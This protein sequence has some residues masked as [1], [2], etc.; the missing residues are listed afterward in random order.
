VIQTLSIDPPPSAQEAAAIRAALAV[1]L[2]QHSARA[3]ANGGP[4]HLRYR[5][6]ICDDIPAR[7]NWKD[8]ARL[9]ALNA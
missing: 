7:L 1:L 3:N 9:E 6:V 8:A 4:S 5:D 2:A